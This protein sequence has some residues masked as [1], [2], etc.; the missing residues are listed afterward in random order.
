MT[1]SSLRKVLCLCAIAVVTGCAIVSISNPG[2][3]VQH[4]VVIVQENRSF[5]NMFN[6]YPGADTAQVASDHGQILP[7]QPVPLENGADP[8]H[9]HG[10]WWRD[11]DNGK[12]DGFV[13]PSP[14]NPFPYPTYPLAYV[15]QSETVPLW[16]LAS[17]YVLAD[18]MFQSN[19]GPSFPAHQYI[20]A[21]QSGDADENP[22]Q[23]PPHQWG[24]D[25]P[26]DVRVY[27]IGPNGTDVQPGVYPCFDYSTLP[28][29]LDAKGISWR[30]YAP[31]I[32]D[33]G[34][35]GGGY[36]WSALDAI[37]H[38]R[39][40]TDWSRNVTSPNYQVLTDIQ[41]GDLAQVTWVIPRGA[42]SDHAAVGISSNGPDWVTTVVN[43]IGA[44]KFWDSTVIFITWD[45]WGGWYDHVPPPQIDNMGLGFRV[46][47]LVVSPWT[48][49]GYISHQNHEF[50]S[51]LRYTEETFGLP[52][53]STRD[54]IS[55]DLSD[56]FDFS[57]TLR[58]Y[59]QIPV[60]H[61]PSFFEQMA[62]DNK[63]PDDY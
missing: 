36:V 1:R 22:A 58:P 38:I 40:G 31:S 19:T 5:D 23:N 60:D 9:S 26:P 11:W 30:Y 51:I 39:Y 25:A 17:R 8:D 52:S 62:P 37:R 56:C 4:I 61:G 48:K 27:L 42:Y 10:G 47:L 41:N 20:I 54:A 15:P 53:L 13:H 6:G 24:C 49:H 21:G 33:P 12:M 35:Y 18:R 2:P 44:S 46:P 45:D 7:L 59:I 50:G 28:D 57:Q 43:T 3:K 63:P 34:A 14:G 55:D 29:L 32:N 16:T